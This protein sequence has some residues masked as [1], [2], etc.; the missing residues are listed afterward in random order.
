MIAV[1]VLTALLAIAFL[2]GRRDPAQPLPFLGAGLIVVA[3]LL[4]WAST[5]AFLALGAADEGNPVMAW[6]LDRWWLAGLL[7]VKV[8]GSLWL[9]RYAWKRPSLVPAI[10]FY[11]TFVALF[12]LTLG[13][14]PA[15][16]VL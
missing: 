10:V 4:D 5:A 12:N 13:V 16:G 2:A 7:L 6:V 14:L 1:G 3:N 8:A 15:L 9:C 11:F